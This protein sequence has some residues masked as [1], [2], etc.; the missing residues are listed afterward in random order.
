MIDNY[1]NELLRG[2]ANSSP[3]FIT[4]E[5]YPTQGAFRFDPYEGSSRCNDGFCELSINWVDNENA[6]D[7]L[8]KQINIR[9]GTPQFQGG[10]CRL[11]K[12]IINIALKTYINNEHFSYER[13]PIKATQEN[14]NQGNPFHGNLLLKDD[15]DKAAK[16]NIQATLAAIAGMVIKRPTESESKE[17]TV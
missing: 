6:V 12:Q 8:L 3:E 13:R 11:E 10:Y 16:T 9:K 15:L 7:T 5:G 2:I 1:P 4:Q 17:K 14:G